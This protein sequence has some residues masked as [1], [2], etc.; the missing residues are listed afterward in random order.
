[1]TA[2]RAIRG[3][4][5]RSSFSATRIIKAGRP[6]TLR[7]QHGIAAFSAGAPLKRTESTITVALRGRYHDGADRGGRC[8]SH[9]FLDVSAGATDPAV[10]AA[11]RLVVATR[12]MATR[13]MACGFIVVPPRRQANRVA[14]AMI[15]AGSVAEIWRYP[16]KSMGG[17]RVA[18]S[19][20]TTRGVH[21]DR[22]WAV[23]DVEL[24]T[25]TTARRWPILLQ[26]SARFVEEPAGRSAEPGEVLEVIVTF[27]G[28]EEVSSSDP[29]IHDR[30]S[31]Q[32]GKPARLESLPA[33]SE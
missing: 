26:C 33:L 27:P 22:M 1:M 29:A 28:G 7:F 16:V 30:L 18:R 25:F 17:E 5:A 19:A 14:G 2:S 24:D 10:A 6:R 12:P 15:V 32:I 4:L 13:R 23:R 9:V 8:C 31:E 20:I 11:S 3:R 21:A